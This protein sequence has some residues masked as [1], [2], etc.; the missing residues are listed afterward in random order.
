MCAPSS[1]ATFVANTQIDEE[2]EET[3][4]VSRKMKK[5]KKKRSSA[6]LCHVY[7]VEITCKKFICYMYVCI[8][9]STH[10]HHHHHLRCRRR[11][12][13]RCRFQRWLLGFNCVTLVSHTH[14]LRCDARVLVCGIERVQQPLFGCILDIVEDIKFIPLSFNPHS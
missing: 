6:S 3:T 13:W 1:P 5:M 11:R 9:S 12:G 4:N 8:A 7:S 2:A 10:H 14:T